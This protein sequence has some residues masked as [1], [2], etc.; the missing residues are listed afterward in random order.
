M[1]PISSRIAV[2]DRALVAVLD[3]VHPPLD[4]GRPRDRDPRCRPEAA[5]TTSPKR[6]PSSRGSGSSSGRRLNGTSAWS[7]LGSRPVRR[8][9]ATAPATAATST[10]LTV[11]PSACAVR[12][13]RHSVDR[14][15]QATRCAACCSPRIAVC[16]VRSPAAAA[17]QGR[18]RRWRSRAARARM[19]RRRRCTPAQRASRRRAASAPFVLTSAKPAWPGRPSSVSVS[20]TRASAMPSAIAVV[21]AHEHRGA[22]AVA[23]DQVDLPQRARLVQRH[24]GQVPT[25]ACSARGPRAPG[26]RADGSAASGRSRGRPP[27][28]RRSRRRGRAG[29]S[30]RSG[31]RCARGTTARS[32][33]QSTGS[34][35]HRTLLITIRFVGRSMCSQA[36]SALPMAWRVLMAGP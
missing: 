22:G 29:G 27:S 24:G 26:A 30:G 21:H 1:R 10:S 35:N 6:L 5:S 11:A 25:S 33:S 9:S 13:T 18:R 16:G 36:A 17:C 32:A 31:R 14:L 23:V 28:G 19:Q 12:L 2:G 3:R 15:D 4:L 20:I 7:S 8:R 34:S